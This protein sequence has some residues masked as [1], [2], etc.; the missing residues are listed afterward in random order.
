MLVLHINFENFGSLLLLTCAKFFIT[1]VLFNIKTSHKDSTFVYTESLM[2]R[3]VILDHDMFKIKFAADW[4]YN[5]AHVEGGININDQNP[6]I[7]R[8]VFT[9]G[10]GL[11]LYP[12]EFLYTIWHLTSTQLFAMFCLMY[13]AENS[14]KSKKWFTVL[15]FFVSVASFYLGITFIEVSNGATELLQFVPL[16]ILLLVEAKRRKELKL[17]FTGLSFWVDPNYSRL[18]L[19]NDLLADFLSGFM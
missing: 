3:S 6:F 5:D 18:G 2:M 19:Q 13:N 8:I 4:N 11:C 15:T 14:E 16:S 10:N 12:I 17:L 1:I 7:F 9:V